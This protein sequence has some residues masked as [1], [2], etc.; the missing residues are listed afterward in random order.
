MVWWCFWQSLET[1]QQTHQHV[2]GQ[3][4]YSWTAASA[5]IFCLIC[6]SFPPCN[7]SR[8]VLSI[9]RTNKVHHLSSIVFNNADLSLFSKTHTDPIRCFN[10]DTKR[11]CGVILCVPG[12]PADNPQQSEE[13]SHMG[14]NA[15]C[16]C[17]KCKAGGN[18]KHTE[19]DQGYH[20]LHFVS[21]SI[22][23]WSDQ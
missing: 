17:R 16:K 4:K 14:G 12:L 19:S 13:S 3:L 18:H 5:R 23:P 6:F 22:W 11:G 2:H 9:T 20:S 10:A 21:H 15:N 8:T 1:V 7:R